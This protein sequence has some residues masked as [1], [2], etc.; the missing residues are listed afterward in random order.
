[1]NNNIED[2][3]KIITDK[4]QIKKIFTD[5][6]SSAKTMLVEKNKKLVVL[7]YATWSGIGSS[8]IPWLKAQS[9]RLKALKK[10]LPEAGAKAIPF[11]YEQYD[12][13]NLFYYTMEYFSDSYPLSIYYFAHPDDAASNYLSD[14]KKLISF[15]SLN[16][17]SNG[18]LPVPKN[19]VEIVHLTKIKYRLSYLTQTHGEFYKNFLE[20]KYLHFKSKIYKDLS[21]L[22]HEILNEQKLIINNK[23]YTNAPLILSF[24]E[25]SPQIISNLTPKFLPKY[26]HGDGTLRNYLKLKN[27]EFIL[28]DVRGID[29]PNNAPSRIC[30]PYELG[31]IL[32]TFYLEVV[33]K[34]LFSINVENDGKY[35]KYTLEYD[36]SDPSVLVFFDI[37]KKL[38]VTMAQHSELN[39]ILTKEPNWIEK[40]F[41]AEA[42]HFLADA[43]N[44][45]ESDPKGYQTI[46]Y[47]LIGTILLNEYCERQNI[48]FF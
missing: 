40:V 45:L 2:I 30:I 34:N 39:L 19:Y 44:R 23:L 43:S 36:S 20:K 10:Q 3:P 27:G 42:C 13:D 48:K 5:G 1:M 46:A 24:I 11:V 31:K 7:K 6:G 35:I 37:R 9:K 38:E 25:K 4:Y 15:L 12:K 16:V 14:I 47:Y 29:L 33:R 28:I 18:K 21:S 41:F 32:R 8:G 17:Y 26:A 22:F